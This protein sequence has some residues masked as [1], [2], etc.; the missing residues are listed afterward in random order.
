KRGG[1]TIAPA[2]IEDVLV[3]HPDV[4][5]A[6]AFSVPHHILGETVGCVIVPRSGRHVDLETLATHLSKHLSPAKWPVI[7]VYMDS[8]PKNAAGK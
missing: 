7:A 8:L 3:G 5:A 2:E 1:E 4:L 6:L